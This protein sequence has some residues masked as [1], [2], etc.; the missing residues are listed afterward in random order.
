MRLC[1]RGRG[2]YV[3]YIFPY[4]IYT[5]RELGYT[6]FFITIPWC[7]WNEIYIIFGQHIYPG[8]CLSLYYPFIIFYQNIYGLTSNILFTLML[9]STNDLKLNTTDTVPGARVT[10]QC[11]LY[12]WC[13]VPYYN[14]LNWSKWFI[15][16][17][18]DWKVLAINLGLCNL[19][20]HKT[21]MKHA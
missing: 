16:R 5:F 7:G 17:E 4:I 3:T 2:L 10:M 14:T 18:I 15:Q 21:D 12:V 13:H 6:K 19:Q 11:V 9:S 8:L 20:R 1:I